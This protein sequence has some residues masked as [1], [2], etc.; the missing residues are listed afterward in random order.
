MLAMG[1]ASRAR[2]DTTAGAH[3]SKEH[4]DWQEHIA[5]SDASVAST[6]LGSIV[7]TGSRAGL[8]SARR[9]ANPNGAR[10]RSRV[11]LMTRSRPKRSIRTSFAAPPRH[12]TKVT[13]DDR[14]N[15]VVLPVGSPPGT[16]AEGMQ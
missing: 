13:F 12:P 10:V 1:L 2:L 7:R 6:I 3:A 5:G 14:Q 15:N 8:P 4:P 9:M 11:D 16:K